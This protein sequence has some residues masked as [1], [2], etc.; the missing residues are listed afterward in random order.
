MGIQRKH[1]IVVLVALV[2]L[3]VAAWFLLLGPA[4]PFKKPSV[5]QETE[6]VVRAKNETRL[7]NAT[8]KIISYLVKSLD[9]A[10]KSERMAIVG[11]ELDNFFG[12]SEL[13]ITFWQD[14][15]EIVRRLE[16][17]KSYVFR[18]VENYQLN[19]FETPKD[20]YPPV[21]L[22]P[23]LSTPMVV[24]EKMLEMAEVDSSDVVYDLGSGDGRIVITAAKK[25]GA[26][27]VGIDIDHWQILESRAN[28][29]KAGVE[30]LVEFRLQDVTEADFSEATVVTLYLL[31]SSNVLMSPF[32]EDQLKP[33]S[34]VVSH[35]YKILGWEERE[36]NFV[37]L[38]GEDG[39]R[40]SIYLYQR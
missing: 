2:F 10:G 12:N 7:R 36:V 34:Y 37:M 13:E 17:G 22:A 31:T 32:L 1:T 23:Y 33:G 28:A 16:P 15:K 29:K 40:H 5:E 27:G 38:M 20:W 25:Y 26:R 30:N 39:E 19:I 18:Y 14:E 9:S 24:V 11:G 4:A 3:A 35:K 21:D 8:R 6:A